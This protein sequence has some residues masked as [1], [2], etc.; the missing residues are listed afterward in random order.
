MELW[1]TRRKAEKSRKHV[2]VTA[3]WKYGW[4]PEVNRECDRQKRRRRRE[5]TMYNG[6][7][8]ETYWKWYLNVTT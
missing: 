4:K 7:T 8:P 5:M 1:K 6:Y 3:L 2:K